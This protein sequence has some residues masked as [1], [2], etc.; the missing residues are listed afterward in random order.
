MYY[1]PETFI[2]KDNVLQAKSG[3]ER[4]SAMD[5]FIQSTSPNNK[6]LFTIQ[7]NSNNMT[8]QLVLVY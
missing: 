2:P 1:P 6:Y 7:T 4:I 3:T 8:V 5:C